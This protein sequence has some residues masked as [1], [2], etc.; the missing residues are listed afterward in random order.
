MMDLSKLGKEKEEFPIFTKKYPSPI[1]ALVVEYMPE[2][3]DW[4]LV[5]VSVYL[6]DGSWMMEQIAVM[7]L[8]EAVAVANEN[9]WFIMTSG[10]MQKLMK[11][12]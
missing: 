8:N 1:K 7:A 4:K 2:Y 3:S 10:F 11:E 5:N 12:E 9:D 6:E